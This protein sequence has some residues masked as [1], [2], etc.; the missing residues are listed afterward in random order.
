MK[1][2]ISIIVVSLVMSFFVNG[3][4]IHAEEQEVVISEQDKEKLRNLGFTALVSCT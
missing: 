4:P 1:K 3:L 2:V